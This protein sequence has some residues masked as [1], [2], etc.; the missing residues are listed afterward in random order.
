M[1]PLS[2]QARDSLRARKTGAAERQCHI[3]ATAANVRSSSMDDIF[4]EL[5]RWARLESLHFDAARGEHGGSAHGSLLSAKE[6]EILALRPRTRDE[7]VVYLRFCA[8]FLERNSDKGSLAAEAIR[9]AANAM[10]QV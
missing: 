4:S 8:V 7:L 10:W 6:A 1:S 3:P 5:E 9:K 2:T